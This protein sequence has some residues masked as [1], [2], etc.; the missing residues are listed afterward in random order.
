MLHEIG[1]D[2]VHPTSLDYN[3]LRTA[4][5][6]WQDKLIFAGGV[7]AD[8]LRHGDQ[9]TIQQ[10]VIESC[11]Q[12]SADGG[13]IFGVSGAITDDIPPENYVV[14]TQALHQHGRNA[15]LRPVYH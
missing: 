5:E 1:F 10:Q 12:L 7:S 14:M 15:Y 6:T 9:E 2:I 3:G 13:Y 4:K 8:T 11:R